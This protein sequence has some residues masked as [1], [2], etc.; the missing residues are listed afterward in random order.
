MNNILL[1]FVVPFYNVDKYIEKCIHSLYCQD[2]PTDRYEVILINDCS[3]DRSRDLVLELKK[4]YPSLLLLEHSNNKNHGGARN[5][6]T[7]NASGKYIWYVDS[8][9]FIK[10]NVV[11]TLLDI[12]IE[13]ELD[14]LHFDYTRI[15]NDNSVQEYPEN[16][17]TGVLDG[18]TFF[19]T[20][21]EMWWK[22]NVEVW[23]RLHK[24]N[25]LVE[26]CLKFIEN[27]YYE[28]VIFSIEVFSKAKR[29]MHIPESPY[30]YRY[31][32]ESFFNVPPNGEKLIK[33]LSS[34]IICHKLWLKDDLD[35]KFYPLIKDFV[36]YHFKE[37]RRIYPE[38]GKE[39]QLTFNSNIK[40]IS[41]NVVRK[42]LNFED[43]F[44][45]IFLKMKSL[46]LF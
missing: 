5:T 4:K 37:V 27:T 24:R 9:D 3:P 43:Y 2:I 40:H 20:N 11:G 21:N 6:G 10:P 29:V 39:E 14:V 44:F 31:N 41:F 35:S 45:Y 13:N 32:P 7:Q 1:S 23:R 16:S 30:F 38:L 19:F 22:R 8:D 25:F 34:A 46:I 18:I 42:L 15:F 26:N 33:S 12:A 36:K 17:R 28:D